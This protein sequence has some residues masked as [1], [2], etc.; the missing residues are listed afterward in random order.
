MSGNRAECIA[1]SDA[2]QTDL[3]FEVI[4][5]DIKDK[6]NASRTVELG[7]SNEIRSQRPIVILDS[8]VRPVQSR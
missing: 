5:L 7:S 4:A 6:V 3:F 8:V 1:S 2:V